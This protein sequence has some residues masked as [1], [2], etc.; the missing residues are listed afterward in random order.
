MRVGV[1]SRKASEPGEGHG[2][3]ADRPEHVTPLPEYPGS[4]EHVNDPVVSWH[5]ASPWQLWEAVEHSLMLEHAKP[6]PENPALHWQ[7]KLPCVSV[8]RA[9]A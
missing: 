2:P 7:L 8:H 9:L 5:V 1:E 6:L 4:H 3:R